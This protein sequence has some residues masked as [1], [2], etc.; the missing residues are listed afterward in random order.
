MAAEPERVEAEDGHGDGEVERALFPSLG[1]LAIGDGELGRP[2]CSGARLTVQ[3][4]R[5]PTAANCG[6]NTCVSGFPAARSRASAKRRASVLGQRSRRHH[7]VLCRRS[8]PAATQRELLRRHDAEPG[9]DCRDP[10]PCPGQED[11]E[12]G[13]DLRIVSPCALEVGVAPPD[14]SGAFVRLKPHGPQVGVDEIDVAAGAN[15]SRSVR[16]HVLC[17]ADPR[18]T[19]RVESSVHPGRRRGESPGAEQ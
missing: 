11:M 15:E 7:G 19:G 14:L 8:R 17:P 6:W 10:K 5:R 2:D 12:A 16:D 13:P 4:G 18:G 9:V 1:V 3:P